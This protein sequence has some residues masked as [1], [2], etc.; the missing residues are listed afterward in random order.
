MFTSKIKAIVVSGL[1]LCCASSA[2]AQNLYTAPGGAM[3]QMTLAQNACASQVAT[4][5]AENDALR[6]QLIAVQATIAEA[7]ALSNGLPTKLPYCDW[8]DGVDKYASGQINCQGVTVL[9]C[10]SSAGCVVRYK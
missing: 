6:N 3:Q 5:T 8:A 9:E 4:L 7:Y 2:A 1:I 10:A